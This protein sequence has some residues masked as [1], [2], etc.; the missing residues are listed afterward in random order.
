MIVDKHKDEKQSTSKTRFAD[1]KKRRYEQ[2]EAEELI[3]SESNKNSK[4][5]NERRSRSKSNEQKDVQKLA[6][7]KNFTPSKSKHY[8]AIQASKDSVQIANE[9]MCELKLYYEYFDN[10]TP[11]KKKS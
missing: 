9:I 1:F 5:L 3:K 4:I 11:I 10:I 2:I 7:S 6:E 8:E